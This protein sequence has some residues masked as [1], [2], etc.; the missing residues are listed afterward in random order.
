MGNILGDGPSWLGS[1]YAPFDVAGKARQNMS[2]QGTLNQLSERRELLKGLD[3]LDRTIDQTTY[4][5]RPPSEQ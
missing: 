4:A 5:T 1:P 2:L 3:T